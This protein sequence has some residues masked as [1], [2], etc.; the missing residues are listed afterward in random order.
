M[1]ADDLV[2]SPLSDATDSDAD[3]TSADGH[4]GTDDYH[5]TPRLDL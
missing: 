1:R 4:D 5:D 3:M 2:I